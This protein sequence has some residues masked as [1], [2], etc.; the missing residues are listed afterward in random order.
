[1]SWGMIDRDEKVERGL[2]DMSRP[3]ETDIGT[4]LFDVYIYK[5]II[6]I[7]WPAVGTWHQG[8]IESLPMICCIGVEAAVER[9]SPSIHLSIN[10]YSCMPSFS[11]A[12]KSKCSILLS[13]YL[14]IYLSHLLS[15]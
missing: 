13:I 14:S 10:L 12:G 1:M 9:Y 2:N 11:L 4:W 8:L 6:C 7:A 3:Y 15:R 5:L